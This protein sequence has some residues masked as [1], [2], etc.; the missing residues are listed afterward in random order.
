MVIHTKKWCE[1]SF[2]GPLLLH[3]I[4][5]LVICKAALRVPSYKINFTSEGLPYIDSIASSQKLKVND[6]LQNM[7]TITRLASEEK[8]TQP[9][10]NT[11]IFL[12]FS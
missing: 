5:N 4:T 10:V 2:K 3:C 6:I 11:I 1:F 9:Y 8:I 7:T 12:Q